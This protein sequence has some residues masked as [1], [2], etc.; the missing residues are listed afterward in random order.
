MVGNLSITFGQPW[1]LILIPLILPP[2]VGMSFRSLA[3]LGSVAG[4]WRSCC[5][6][7]SSR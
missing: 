5:G 7:G 3:G 4:R 2:L 1:W 6:R